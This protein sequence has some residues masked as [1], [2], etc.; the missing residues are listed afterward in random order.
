MAKV[1]CHWFATFVLSPGELP[2]SSINCFQFQND[3]M[4]ETIRDI[5]EQLINCVKEVIF[6]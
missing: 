2:H 3:K 4:E 5:C 1:P 6:G